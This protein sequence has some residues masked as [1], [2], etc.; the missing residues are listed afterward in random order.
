MKNNV[1]EDFRYRIRIIL[2]EVKTPTI[3]MH[4][5]CKED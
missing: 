5:A 1:K 2:I 3:L 4:E